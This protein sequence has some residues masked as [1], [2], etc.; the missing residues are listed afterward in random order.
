MKSWLV[1]ATIAWAIIGSLV[2]LAVSQSFRFSHGWPSDR[3]ELNP[4]PR[5]HWGS[6][7]NGF[8]F[9]LLPVDDSS[10]SISIRFA[11]NVG[12]LR[13]TDEESGYAHLIEHLAFEGAG[14]FS[15]SDIDRLFKDLGLQ[16]GNDVNGFT[17]HHYTSY[18][19]ELK[20]KDAGG[21]DEA[22]RLFRSFADGIHFEVES[23]E[24]QKAIVLAE[25]LKYDQPLARF[26]EIAFEHAMKG[27]LYETRPVVGNKES[28]QEATRERLIAFYK[29]WYRPESMTLFVVGNID[30]S[31]LERQITRHFESLESRGRATPPLVGAPLGNQAPRVEVAATMGLRRTLIDLS[32]T[33]HEP[34]VRDSERTRE[35]DFLRRFATELLNERCQRFVGNFNSDFLFYDTRFETSYVHAR[36]TSSPEKWLTGVRF[37]DRMIRQATRYGFYPDEIEHLQNQWRKRIRNMAW[38]RNSND[39]SKIASSL[40]SETMAGRVYLSSNELLKLDSRMLDRLDKRELDQ[41]LKDLWKTNGI[42][43]SLGGELPEKVNEREL[44]R[45]FASYRKLNVE[46]YDYEKPSIVDWKTPDRKGEVIVDLPIDGYDEARR[47]E[48]DNSTQLTFLNTEHEPGSVHA[49]VR[50]HL[51]GRESPASSNPALRAVALDSFLW[52]GVEG[53][54][55]EEIQ[56][57]LSSRLF[58]FSYS[59][60]GNDSICFRVQCDPSELGWITQMISAY[61]RG[62]SVS[63][64]GFAFAK[65]SMLRGLQVELDG[66]TLA[67]RGVQRTLFPERPELWDPKLEEGHVLTRPGVQ[68]WLGERIENGWIEVTVVGDASKDEVIEVVA[69]SLGRLERKKEKTISNLDTKVE[70]PAR[71]FSRISYPGSHGSGALV[72]GNWILEPGPITL[73]EN[74]ALVFA[75]RIMRERIDLALRKKMAVSYETRVDYWSLPAFSAFQRFRIEADCS[76]ENLE[77]ALEL[78]ESAF[79]K[80]A[81][82]NLSPGEVERHCE[83]LEREYQSNTH[84]NGYIV[85]NVLFSVSE[86]PEWVSDW[87]EINGGVLKEITQEMIVEAFRKWLPWEEAILRSVIP[88]S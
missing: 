58:E 12:S 60:E 25:K 74:L 32:R 85:E 69:G 14:S 47:I 84:E 61:L 48:F 67:K 88:Q 31:Q 10:G 2:P 11:V 50:L 15:G 40:E 45:E 52:S 71:G 49:L 13:E 53:F 16:M 63:E 46:P 28:L 20:E 56:S 29:K 22:L 8:R 1:R 64:R 57:E 87:N 27:T 30:S 18:R 36:L 41:E 54:S 21:L 82:G 26:S 66:M 44:S 80:L 79:R 62:G 33:W 39:V 76:P 55:W 17:T 34:R 5:V 37:I 75:E 59:I 9:A 73:K 72:I 65:S 24:K 68:E 70:R 4:D 43:L 6:L 23:V 42:A 78:V 51:P 77:L 3:S 86:R 81:E 19:L 35:R 7:E 38:I 83:L